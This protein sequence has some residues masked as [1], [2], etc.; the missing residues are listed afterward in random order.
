MDESISMLLGTKRRHL[1]T[2]SGALSTMKLIATLVLL[3]SMPALVGADQRA[4]TEDGRELILRDDGTW[5]YADEFKKDKA[6][7]LQ[8]TGKRGAFA[9]H[10]VPG[11]W[12][13]DESRNAAVEVMLSHKD[14]DAWAMVIA[15]RIMI[16][17]E[18]LKRH[19]LEHARRADKDAKIVKEE[20]RVVNGKE[21]LCLIINVT[22]DGVPLTWYG[23]YYTGDEGSFQALTW[24]FQNVFQELKPEL[25]AFLN[26]LEILKK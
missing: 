13:K 15:E 26:G 9:L 8:Y 23:Y 24:T 1:L 14:A 21:V 5:V 10:L 18:A 22:R 3:L 16:T 7:V 17:P 11:A 4:K 19:A 25:E 2:A 12:K 20:K 6:A